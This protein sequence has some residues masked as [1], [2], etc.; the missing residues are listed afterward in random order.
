MTKKTTIYDI[1]KNVGTSTATVSRV[2][3]NSGYPVKE[4]LKDAILKTA[5]DM[6]YSPNLIGRILKGIQSKEIGVIIPN[7]SNPYYPQIL[8]G[9]ELE[10]RKHGYN[11]LLCNSFRDVE[12]EKKYIESLY[13][14]Q[15]K[16]IIISSIDEN[17]GFLREM[18]KTGVKVVAFDQDI[19]DIKCKKVGFNFVGGGVM[20]VEYLVKMGHKNIAFLSSPITKKSRKDTLAGYKQAM[21]ENNIEVLSENIV[22]SDN[23]KESRTGIYEFENGKVLAKKFL[24]IENRPSAIV[25]INDMTAFGIMQE[26]IENGIDIPEDVSVIGFDNIE[27]ASLVNPPLTTIDQSSFETGEIA[28]KMLIDDMNNEDT[29]D[30]V[31]ILEPELVVRRS[32]KKL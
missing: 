25:A 19:E 10:A 13:Q 9:I 6:N 16:G 3:S 17:H 5:K 29:V 28:C 32:V 31:V 27:I 15:V 12:T 4:E 7:I 21:E 26:L 1:A 14:K 20:A 30:D 11:I 22:I 8:L 24:K 18:Q 2:L 23:E